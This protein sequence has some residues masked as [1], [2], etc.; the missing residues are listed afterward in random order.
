M[1]KINSPIGI[2]YD[3]RKHFF[4]QINN[5]KGKKIDIILETPGGY[6]EIVEDLVEY[7]SVASILK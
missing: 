3:D 4:D 1:R 6:A 2:D 5:L 7:T